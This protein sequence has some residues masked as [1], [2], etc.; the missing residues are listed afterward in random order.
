MATTISASTVHRIAQLANIPV[1]SDEE[2]KLGVA[3]TDTLK[4]IEH[5]SQLNT[6]AVEPT[7]QVTGL[8]NVL[9]PD[10]ISN[11]SFTQAQA[12]ANAPQTHEGY[13]V[14]PQIINQD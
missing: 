6:S 5:M 13:F 14:V 9:R 10:K 12:L 2:T 8:E 11:T 3:F 4:V 7:H 1:A